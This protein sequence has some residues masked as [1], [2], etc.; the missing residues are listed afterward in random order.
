MGADPATSPDEPL[1]LRPVRTIKP[2]A[3]EVEQVEEA[4]TPK[5]EEH[6]LRQ[7]LECPPAPRKQRWP[8]KRKS[9]PP[10]RPHRLA[11]RNLAASAFVPRP[12][13]KLRL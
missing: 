3:V 6:R 12:K 2:E 9:S 1:E 5:A 11:P 13:K 4:V 7:A 10:R 8:T